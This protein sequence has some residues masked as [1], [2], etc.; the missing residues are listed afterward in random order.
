MA[1]NPQ[2]HMMSLKGKDYLQVAWRL[3]WF[4]EE[5]PLWAIETEPV[6]ITEDSAMFRCVIKD[7]TG[8]VVSTG[9]GY[10]TKKDF[11]DNREKAE[12]KAVGRALAMLGYGTQFAPELDEEDRIVDSPVQQPITIMKPTAKDVEQLVEIVR[13]PMAT[14]QQL[15][16][17]QKLMK[18]KGVLGSDVLKRYNIK[19]PADMT[20]A[21]AKDC[22]SGLKKTR[23]RG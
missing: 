17:I 6:E 10:E 23:A 15:G 11:P 13:E 12:T 20:E 2:E 21:M 8:R 14:A 16:E 4:R 5:K 22:I 3:V 1:F 9:H 19:S 18:E 7:E